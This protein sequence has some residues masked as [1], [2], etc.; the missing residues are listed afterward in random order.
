[1]RRLVLD[2]IGLHFGDVLSCGGGRRNSAFVIIFSRKIL[3]VDFVCRRPALEHDDCSIFSRIVILS[4]YHHRFGHTSFHS[5]GIK[6]G[7]RSFRDDFAI[8]ISR[9]PGSMA[10][11]LRAPSVTTWCQMRTKRRTSMASGKH[12]FTFCAVGTFAGNSS[13]FGG[14]RLQR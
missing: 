7:H 2:E 1:M 6:K 10:G 13:C 4:C 3:V 12:S 9:F 14:S 8:I 5:D 11:A